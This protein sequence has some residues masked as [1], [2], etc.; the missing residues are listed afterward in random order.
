MSYNFVT[1]DNCMDGA[2]VLS[3]FVLMALLYV[4]IF[5][6]MLNFYIFLKKEEGEGRPT[7]SVPVRGWL[8]EVIG[9]SIAFDT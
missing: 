1:S 7:V 4:Y 9:M 2:F 5:N 3:C 8:D 6:H